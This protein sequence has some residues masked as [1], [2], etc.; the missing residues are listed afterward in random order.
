VIN[1]SGDFRGSSAYRRQMAAVL[2]QRVVHEV[3]DNT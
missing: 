1:P 3:Q 2:A